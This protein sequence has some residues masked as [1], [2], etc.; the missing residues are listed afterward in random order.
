M[1]SIRFVF[2]FLICALIFLSCAGAPQ[3]AAAATVA[4]PADS[5]PPAAAPAPEKSVAQVTVAPSDTSESAV[6]PQ[7]A[8]KSAVPP[9]TTVA[10]PDFDTIAKAVAGAK[11]KRL[12]VVNANIIT[13]NSA[14]VARF[15]AADKALSNAENV[16]NRGASGA[17]AEEQIAARDGAQAALDTYTAILHD[18]W[19]THAARAQRAAADARTD[20]L[21]VRAD[22]AAKESFAQA[23]TA[24]ANGDSAYT[25]N[26]YEASAAAYQDAEAGFKTSAATAI[27]KRRAAFIAVQNANN[28]IK[29]SEKIAVN[30]DAIIGGKSL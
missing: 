23:S 14:D 4:P 3:A 2:S 9:E 15:T 5:K 28:K 6:P 20:A 11:E 24:L 13:K 12:A 26:D 1:N 21:N 17:S 18:Y 16:Y 29:E 7:E 19:P 8:A 30:A 22:I 25:K 27:K 10:R